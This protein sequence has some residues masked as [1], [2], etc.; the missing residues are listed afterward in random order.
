M[1]RPAALITGAAKGIGRQI[2]LTLA[3]KGYDVAVNYHTDQNAAE[4]VCR[5]AESF[6]GRALA[7]YADMSRIKDIKDM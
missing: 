6:G 7:V 3:E 5:E 1:R 2:A 4:E